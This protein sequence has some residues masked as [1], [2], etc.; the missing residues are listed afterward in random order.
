MEILLAVYH[1]RKVL[2][3][4]VGFTVTGLAIALSQ[5]WIPIPESARVW[6][7]PTFYAAII[8]TTIVICLST[9]LW[10]G[11]RHQ[12]AC[13][14]RAE[15]RAVPIIPY[16][17][18]FFGHVFQFLWGK[19]SFLKKARDTS[20][21]ENFTLKL[22]GISHV[23]V[24]SPSAIKALGE[25]DSTFADDENFVL[26]ARKIAFGLGGKLPT[27][28]ADAPAAFSNAFY[29]KVIAEPYI[30]ELI[31]KVL[32]A[33]KE[34]IPSMMTFMTSLV[35][36]TPWERAA[37]TQAVEG[38]GNRM[39]A[40][41]NLLVLI[42]ELAGNMITPALTGAGLVEDY[43]GLHAD[44]QQFEDYFY[45]M[46]SGIPRWVPIPGIPSGTIA[47]KRLLDQL[48]ALGRAYNQV[49]QGADTSY[50]RHLSDFPTMFAVA[51]ETLA[52]GDASTQARASAHLSILWALNSS[53]RNLVFWLLV[54]IISEEGLAERVRKE[55]KP[56]ARATQ[57]PN[58]FGVP[59]PPLLDVDIEGLTTKCP[60]LE[61]CYMETIRL[62]DS[63]WTVRKVKQ[64]FSIH[65]DELVQFEEGQYVN[66]S[67]NL[68]NTSS[69]YYS[70]AEKFMPKRFISAEEG[71]TAKAEWGTVRHEG[72]MWSLGGTMGLA[73]K[74]SLAIVAS[75]LAVWEIEPMSEAGLR[76][77]RRREAPLIAGPKRD[78]RVKISRRDLGPANRS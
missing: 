3:W 18:P 54:H 44:L 37:E 65:D 33:M 70:E 9:R 74:L 51:Q 50:Y 7:A 10:S 53:V 45:L 19:S 36:Q 57:P 56:Y 47:R 41:T 49:S 62:Y 64:D 23:V 13:S 77:P 42:R 59:E 24:N 72:G 34:N 71:Q 21:D 32:G 6:D 17:V 39:F 2:L 46:A 38:A 5:S 67:N 76:V 30:E 66:V 14:S 29:D 4:D 11:R 31:P 8:I 48:A 26:N 20:M 78:V 22:A 43:P 73:H 27:G 63:S 55:A 25:K 1:D 68:H 60:L 75:L 16:W 15:N 69:Q 58:D 52:N 61:A 40:M 28:S 12:N 35:D